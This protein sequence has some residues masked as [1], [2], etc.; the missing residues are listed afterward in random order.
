MKLNLKWVKTKIFKKVGEAIVDGRNVVTANP[1]LRR[2]K[3]V[4]EC[5]KYENM[6]KL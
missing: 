5:E 1:K 3:L 4:F 2:K 6:K